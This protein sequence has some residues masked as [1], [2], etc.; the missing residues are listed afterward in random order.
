MIADVVDGART[1]AVTLRAPPG[2]GKTTR[3]P[4]ALLD[5]VAGQVLVLEPRRIA[6]RAA[7]RRIATERGTRLGHE[8]GYQVRFDDRTRPDTRL[9]VMT[10]GML[11]ARLQR[12][13]FLEGVGAVVF[14]EFHERR[15]D[16]DLALALV[17]TVRREVRPDLAIVV[18][19][20]TF[21]PAPVA[22]WLG[23]ATQVTSEG[24]S[25]PVDVE[26]QPRP[27][28]RPVADR[29]AA[30]V[31]R[32]LAHPGD[33]LVF[34]PGIRA[35]RDTAN[36][37]TGIDAE[38]L[39]LYG[40]M[41]AEDQDKVLTE[42][43]R[44]RVILATNVA[45]TSV[46][47]PGIRTVVDSG[48]AKTLVHDPA[49]GLSRLETQRI[50]RASA[51]QRA[52]RAGR[53]APGRC[54]RLWTEREDRALI[55]E[56]PPEILRAD[57]TQAVLQLRAWGE[58][59]HTMPWFEAP[60]AG[61]IEA[62]DAVLESLGAT[63]GGQISAVGQ[64]L[65]RLPLHPRIGRLLLEAARHGH[66]DDGAWVAALLSER[67]PMGPQRPVRPSSSDLLDRVDVLR[68]GEG[69]SGARSALER[70]AHRL[71]RHGLPAPSDPRHR[72]EAVGRA[73]LAAWPDRVVRRR[74]ADP[75]R[76]RMV[77]GKGVVITRS[78]VHDPFFVAVDLDDGA[79]ATV[80]LASAVDPEWLDV[81]RTTETE[82][83]EGTA[84]TRHLWRYGDLV[85]RSHPAPLDRAAA[86]HALAAWAE[87]NLERVLP[88][89]QGWHQLLARWRAAH[90]W[91]ASVPAPDDDGLRSLLP[92]LCPGLR[93][94]A[95]L[96]SADWHAGVRDALGWA[97]WQ[98]I[99]QLAPA[100]VS[101]SN[102]Q[103]F[104]LDWTGDRPVLSARIQQLLGV[105]TTPT[106][107]PGV[108]V[109]L[110]LLAPNRRVQQVTDDLAGF[111]TG[112]YQQIRKELRA[113]YP[114]HAWPE[115]P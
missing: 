108:P 26:T 107:G 58:D 42:G 103:R 74:E 109:L 28:E 64:Q 24:R 19:S 102:G 12:D 100:E 114:K 101:L 56:T 15:L 22:R 23:D 30:A 53:M 76:G 52:G 96:R 48:L 84:R 88:D 37:L 34:L 79:E 95:A 70:V 8:V 63:R 40:S 99:Q 4:P 27:D 98:R 89:N 3:V 72:D 113:R 1:G 112:S 17:A 44:R 38:V 110:H 10:E 2:A 93:S 81:E 97:T 91:D 43:S 55:D 36:A 62:A 82:I 68:R 85:V 86:A 51:D 78:A 41:A 67:D 73:V 65:A 80:R 77:G 59:P 16:A 25:H 71:M 35:I 31:R 57:L 66:A 105:R 32:A 50:S 49:T 92:S 46:T 6:A 69:P 61:A 5:A 14:D 87:R 7:A 21:D 11:L 47:V 45:E 90:R 83:D 33:V 94:A 111:W 104:P 20:A 18:M 13:P 39:P 75:T 106:V 29:A 54:L 115:D 60:P 9:I